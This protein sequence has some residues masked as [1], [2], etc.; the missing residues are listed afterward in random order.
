MKIEEF[1]LERVQSVYENTVDYNLTESG[2]HPFSLQEILTKEEIASLLSLR[3]G[4]GQTNGSPELR[5]RISSYYPE[6]NRSNILVTN[7]SAEANFLAIWSLLD[8][9]DEVILMQPNYQQIYGLA[10]SFGVTV[11]PFF[12]KEELNWQ[13]DIE[14]IKNLAS[15]KVTMIALC[16]PNNP[17]GT[18]LNNKVREEIIDMAETMNAWI[19]C[20]EIYRGSEVGK[21]ETASFWGQYDKVIVAGGLAKSYGLPGLRIGWLTGPPN[22]IESAWAYHDYTTISTCM[23]SQKIAAYV[24][25]PHIREKIIQRNRSI[26]REN[27]KVVIDW[28]ASHR[29]IFFMIP[30]TAGAI[31][32]IHHTLDISSKE[33]S[34]KLRED[35]SVFVLNGEC[36]NMDKFI[37]LG[38]GSE[39]SFLLKGLELFDEWLKEHS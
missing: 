4:Y 21:K 7:G 37:R 2:F 32:Y 1:E 28:V 14:E 33:L 22:I 36:F 27:L 6:A 9:G 5:D 25:T 23:L 13:P 12:L 34:E 38:L 3:L 18:V 19:Y 31:A 29:D 26:L 30:P 10:R 39:K 15:D 17:T 8:P 35:K 11:K 16:N 20:D 24:L